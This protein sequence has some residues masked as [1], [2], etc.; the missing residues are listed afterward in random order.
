[1]AEVKLEGAGVEGRGESGH[2]DPGDLGGSME[3]YWVAERLGSREQDEQS[4]LR[5]ERVQTL[6]VRALD[7]SSHTVA[8][9][10]GEPAGKVDDVRHT[11]QLNQSERGAVTLSDDLFAND[12]I[13]R[14]VAVLQS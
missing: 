8:C 12:G 9:R 2:L 10:H 14:P 7:L 1:G 4:S 13:E 3:K 11:P 5:G 6:R